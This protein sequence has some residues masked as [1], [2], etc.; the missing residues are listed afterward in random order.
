MND[1]QEARKPRILI[2]DDVPANLGMLV[3]MLEDY[4]FEI[5]IARDGQKGV[6]VAK[7]AQP[8][9]INCEWLIVSGIARYILL[10][11]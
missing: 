1:R 2:I 6:D 4:D 10:T 5:M 11:I 7:Q 8:D 9:L 3:N